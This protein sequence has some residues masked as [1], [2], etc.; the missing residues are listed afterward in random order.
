MSDTAY[1]VCAAILSG[2][3]DEVRK[4]QWQWKEQTF[5]VQNSIYDLLKL[6]SYQMR[7]P[8]YKML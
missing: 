8:T 5:K 1:A 7:K 3:I 6:P 4:L 2:N